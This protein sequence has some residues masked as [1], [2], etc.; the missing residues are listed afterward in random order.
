VAVVPDASNTTISVTTTTANA[1][2]RYLSSYAS[3]QTFTAGA[4]YTAAY[5]SSLGRHG[6]FN[7][8]VGAAGTKSVSATIGGSD[9]WAVS[10]IAY[11]TG[12]PATPDVTIDDAT[13]TNA[14]GTVTVTLHISPAAVGGETLN[15]AT[16]DGTATAGAYYT[17]KSGTLTLTGGQTTATVVVNITA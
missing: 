11:K 17:A 6:Q 9:S 16:A 3:G 5:T 12:A 13:C 10:A 14:D 8:D 2:I 1:Y 15:Y 7:V 4:G